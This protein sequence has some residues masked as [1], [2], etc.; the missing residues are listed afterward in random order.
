MFL[1][2]G[3]TPNPKN[4]TPWV[5]WILIGLN[6]GIFIL[7]SMPLSSRQVDPRDPL[8][9]E[10]L[11]TIQNQIPPNV[12]PMQIV[13]Q[14][15]QYDLFL[16]QHGYKPG[17]PNWTD[18]F[19]SMFLHG[20]LLHLLGNM[21]FLW[22]YGDNVE[23]RIGRFSYLVVYVVTG[24]SATLF[25]RLFADG[26]MIP[27]VGA[28]GAISGVLGLYFL[29]FPRNQVKVFIF[30]FP[31]I[32]DVFLLPARWVLGV[33]L[34]FD[35]VLP[36]L[37]DAQS[38]VAYG[39]HIGGFLAG[40]GIAFLGERTDWRLR[41]AETIAAAPDEPAVG[42]ESSDPLPTM[43]R[44]AIAAGRP[45]RAL[46]LAAR[47]RPA[48]LA[49]LEPTECVQLAGWMEKAGYRAAAAR[50]LRGCISRHRQDHL[51]EVYLQ[52]GLLRLK[53]GQETAAYQHLLDAIDLTED[54]QVKNQAR[55]ALDT[56]NLYKRR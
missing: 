20:G 49:G 30:L 16:F 45:R 29:M 40:W 52:L 48:H 2:T 14:L 51:G 47:A 27:M 3:D 32:M 54:P 4:F 56:I 22:I 35:N 26:A 11:H 53:Q 15:S 36:F 1:P 46:D 24:I 10:Y 23:H 31:F 42:A 6:I 44:Q 8:V 34:F 17:A 43:L 13:E 41:G 5:N 50:V 19:F 28:S 9:I 39:A 33:Y 7:V 21:L 55:E 37:V 25:F 12:H 38:G 18:L